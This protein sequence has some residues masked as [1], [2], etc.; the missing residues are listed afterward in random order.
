HYCRIREIERSWR[1]IGVIG[2][3]P[4]RE[5]TGTVLVPGRAVDQRDAGQLLYHDLLQ[6][7]KG[8]LLL[9]GVSG[10]S[11]LIQQLIGSRVHPTLKVRIGLLANDRAVRA[12]QQRV[13]QVEWRRAWIGPG[14]GHIV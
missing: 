7:V 8:L 12:V 14:D 2:I 11:I 1:G 13:E 9:R 10:R 4:A 6:A 5:V 3:G